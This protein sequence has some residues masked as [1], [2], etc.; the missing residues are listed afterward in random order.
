MSQELIHRLRGH[1]IVGVLRPTQ[2]TLMI[3]NSICPVAPTESRWR[4]NRGRSRSED[5]DPLNVMRLNFP[6]AAS[7][8]G[9]GESKPNG[10]FWA[11]CSHAL[12][13][14]LNGPQG[15]EAPC[16]KKKK[17]ERRERESVV[18]GSRM[19]GEVGAA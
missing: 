16:N 5:A 1:I 14:G 19:F 11:P 2:D 8:N 10:S 4:P 13:P 15:G 18:V 3:L 7:T 17:R 6:T 9:A 12:S